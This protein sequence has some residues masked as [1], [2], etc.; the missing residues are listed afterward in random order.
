MAY[1]CVECGHIFEEGEQEF[2]SESRGE[3]FGFDCS[4]DMCGCPMCRGNFEETT[5]CAICGAEHFEDELNGGVCNDCIDDYRND[6]KMCKKISAEEKTEIHINSLL[7]KLFDVATMEAVLCAYIENKEPNV[8]CSTYI[9]EDIIWF[10][11]RL[12]EEVKKNENSKI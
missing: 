9:N 7:A 6:F 2:W 1:K 4:E 5:P 11:E 8:D 3:Y 12:A 10:G